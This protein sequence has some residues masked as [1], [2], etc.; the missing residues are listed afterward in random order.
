MSA[1]HTDAGATTSATETKAK[2]DGDKMSCC[3][4]MKKGKS[5]CE[6]ASKASAVSNQQPQAQP[7][8]TTE[9]VNS[10]K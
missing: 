10:P 2:C 4:N 5:C 6:G 3:K 7:A 1:E 8:N 9:Q